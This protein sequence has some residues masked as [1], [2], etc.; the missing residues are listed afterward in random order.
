MKNRVSEPNTP[1]RGQSPGGRPKTPPQ[2]QRTYKQLKVYDET[3]TGRP[4]PTLQ[5]IRQANLHKIFEEEGADTPCDICGD[6]YHDYRNCTKEAY[7]ESQD[8]RQDLE[9]EKVPKSQCPNCDRPH[10]GICPCTWCDQP[11]HIAQDC[12]AHFADSSMQARFPWRDRVRKT[13][14]KHYECCHCG[15]SHLFNIYC[16]NVRDPSIV[17]GECRSCGTTTKE[18]AND[19]QYIAIK[20]NIGLCTYC[21][22]LSHRYADCPQRIADHERSKREKKKNKWNNK[23]KGKVRIV[24]GVM[25]REQDSDS[26]LPPEGKEREMEV[27]SL[28]RI[29][30]GTN[31][32]SLHRGEP[33]I[34]PTEPPQEVVCSFCGVATHGHRDCPVLHQYIREQ[35]DAL[36]EIRLNE[37]RQLQGWTSYESQKPI[38]SGEGPL[39]RGDDHLGK[40]LSQDLSPLF[41][42]SKGN[43]TG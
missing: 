1:Q 37:Y 18:H 30:E 39:Q 9:V 34:Q 33:Q 15:E 24:A 43:G 5:Q 27:L 21:Q 4:L 29:G 40:A 2:P 13:L 3:P 35:A 32:L 10:P 22:A 8:V 42:M 11:G 36:A 19:C 20:D 31:T 12:L 25:T 23:K 16:P 41:R 14:I 28:H 26:T 17:P 6:P 38:P 7:L